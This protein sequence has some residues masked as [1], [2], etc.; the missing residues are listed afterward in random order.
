MLCSW[1]KPEQVLRH[2]ELYL[3]FRTVGCM[4]AKTD[5]GPT[6]AYLLLKCTMNWTHWNTFYTWCM[7]YQ[8]DTPF[9]I[10]AQHSVK[11]NVDV[12]LTIFQLF[13]LRLI[14]ILKPA[15]AVCRIIWILNNLR[16]WTGTL[17]ILYVHR[18]CPKSKLQVLLWLHHSVIKFVWSDIIYI[19]YYETVTHIHV[20]MNYY[21][22]KSYSLLMCTQVPLIF[23]LK[24]E[25]YPGD[26]SPQT[27]HT[28]YKHKL[29]ILL[30]CNF[31]TAS[32]IIRD[33]SVV[34]HEQ[35]KEVNKDN[36]YEL[37]RRRHKSTGFQNMS[38]TYHI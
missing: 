6:H 32:E 30:D 27:P 5:E 23:L 4:Y 22:V 35:I 12:W 2:W 14:S 1:T 33:H 3:G 19:L 9:L 29:C 20:T 36:F 37:W 38:H 7:Q 10:I 16:Q 11:V 8:Y 18:T 13:H 31:L 25:V 17:S 24:F 28:N 15:L 34:S 26:D 21:Q